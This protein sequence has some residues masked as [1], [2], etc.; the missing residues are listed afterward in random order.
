MA[1]LGGVAARIV[2]IAGLLVG[3]AGVLALL[4]F[5][6]LFV[7]S[8]VFDG[9]PRVPSQET[10]NANGSA[11]QMAGVPDEARRTAMVAAWIMGT[12]AG[13]H[14]S[15]TVL[16]RGRPSGAAGQTESWTS[17]QAQADN[18]LAAV[19]RM[20]SRLNA[21]Q[22]APFAPSDDTRAI[23]EF[24]PFVESAQHQTAVALSKGYAPQ[25]CEAYKLGLYWGFSTPYRGN[26]P[27]ARNVLAPEIGLYAD[28]LKLSEDLKTAMMGPSRARDFATVMTDGDQISKTVAEYWNSH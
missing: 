28:R 27:G 21:P 18:A 8:R 15:M 3:V 23:I 20:T 10:C 26:D 19:T 14:A 12:R 1:H 7:A 22:P 17:L 24:A 25:I 2:K 5:V 16:L 9:D 11:S 4:I 6:V 13:A